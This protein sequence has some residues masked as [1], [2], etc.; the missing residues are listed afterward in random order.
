[1]IGEA[2]WREFAAM[3]AAVDGAESDGG[4]DPPAAPEQGLLF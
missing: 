2:E 1:V 4:D 3:A